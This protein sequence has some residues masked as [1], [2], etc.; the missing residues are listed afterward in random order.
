MDYPFENLQFYLKIELLPFTIVQ[1]DESFVLFS[2]DIYNHSDEN[3]E[4]TISEMANGVP[5]YM[6]DGAATEITIE[7][8]NDP[9]KQ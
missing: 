3:Y 4:L 1:P 2:F 8:D 6:L 5:S 7:S 9:F